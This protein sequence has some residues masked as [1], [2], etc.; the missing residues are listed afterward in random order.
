MVRAPGLAR[1]RLPFCCVLSVGSKE[2]DDS[3]YVDT[4]PSLSA[5][6]PWLYLTQISSQGPISKHHPN[7][8]S[9]LQFTAEPCSLQILSKVAALVLGPKAS[10][11]ICR[12]S[13][14]AAGA[15]EHGS[16]FKFSSGL[17]R[18]AKI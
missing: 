7:W 16:D 3:S 9:G 10:I 17:T 12:L 6:P 14:L 18:N 4:D 13:C 8:G 5:L 1:S 11:R 2:E 15:W